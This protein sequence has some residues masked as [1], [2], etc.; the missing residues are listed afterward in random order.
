VTGYRVYK[1]AAN[2]DYMRIGET[3]I[4]TFIDTE[5]P[6]TRRDYRVS[7]VG[8]LKEGPASEITGVVFVPER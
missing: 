3:Q 2:G 5:P 6:L 1:R 7:A 4:P 8:P